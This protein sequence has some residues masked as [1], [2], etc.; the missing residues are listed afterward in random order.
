M[1][2]LRNHTAKHIHNC[3]VDITNDNEHHN[4]SYENNELLIVAAFFSSF[5]LFF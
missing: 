3:A 5:S 1:Q 2:P 4:I